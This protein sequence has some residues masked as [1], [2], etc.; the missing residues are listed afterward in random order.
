VGAGH[1]EV[2]A[3]GRDVVRGPGQAGLDHR[4][5]R[6]VRD[7]EDRALA[8]RLGDGVAQHTVGQP[9]DDADVGVEL[10]CLQRDFEVGRIVGSDADDR[11]GGGDAAWCRPVAL[12]SRTT[13]VPALCSSSAMRSARPSSPQTIM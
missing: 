13:V 2:E 9:G 11:G 6:Q 10:P 4:R 5:R 8:V 7:V 3:G 1:H 12:S